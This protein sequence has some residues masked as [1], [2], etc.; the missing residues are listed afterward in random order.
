MNLFYMRLDSYF[1][2]VTDQEVPQNLAQAF[3]D[4]CT[5]LDHVPVITHSDIV[6]WNWKRKDPENFGIDFITYNINRL[7]FRFEC[8]EFGAFDWLL[9]VT[10]R[11]MVLSL[12]N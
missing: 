11:N 10:F 3:I 6:L 2:P 1:L 12:D 4:V 9:E 5:R 8:R 7:I